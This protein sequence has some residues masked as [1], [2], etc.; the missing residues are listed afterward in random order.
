MARTEPVYRHHNERSFAATSS[1][2]VDA[3]SGLPQ[4]RGVCLSGLYRRTLRA[5]TPNGQHCNCRTR[6]PRIG[7]HNSHGRRGAWRLE[8]PSSKHHS[9]GQV[10]SAAADIVVSAADEI[11]GQLQLTLSRKDTQKSESLF[12]RTAESLPSVSP[13]P[14]QNAPTPEG[15]RSESQHNKTQVPGFRVTP[16][17]NSP[18]WR[19]NQ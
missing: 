3:V 15:G 18:K 14:E 10:M 16:Q 8:V 13:Y 19:N 11:P 1:G 6:S 9:A 5:E 4:R 7:D 2:L 12:W 17:H